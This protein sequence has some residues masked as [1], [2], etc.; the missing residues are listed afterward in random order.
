MLT[1]T[2][3]RD[4]RIIIDDPELPYVIVIEVKDIRRNQVRLALDAPSHVRIWRKEL[5]ER[6]HC[7]QE[8]L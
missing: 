6:Q 2:R 8:V 7:D 5:Y 3:K 4:E 1:L